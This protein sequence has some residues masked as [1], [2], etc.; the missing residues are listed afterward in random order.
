MGGHD[1]N[2][3]G[4]ESSPNSTGKQEKEPCGVIR[5]VAEFAMKHSLRIH[6]DGEDWWVVKGEKEIWVKR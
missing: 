2:N 3:V 1:V 5:A 4:M 6:I